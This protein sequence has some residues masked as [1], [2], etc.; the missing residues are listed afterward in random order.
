MLLAQS[1]EPTES[2]A[3]VSRLLRNAKV[4]DGS[5]GPAE[6][7]EIRTVDGPFRG[8]PFK[9]FPKG[10]RVWYVREKARPD[11][12]VAYVTYPNEVA[13]FPAD[14][15]VDG[16]YEVG[17]GGA[18]SWRELTILPPGQKELVH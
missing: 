4:D 7:E 1:E 11:E 14:A 6:P 17:T 13:E 9:Q 8:Y 16:C 2:E 10:S 15:E 12:L 5:E 3:S 18:P